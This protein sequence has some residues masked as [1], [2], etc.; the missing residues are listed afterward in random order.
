MYV[1]IKDIGS[2]M[3]TRVLVGGPQIWLL[4]SILTVVEHTA[5]VHDD[6][7]FISYNEPPPPA[8]KQMTIAL[9]FRL[10]H[11]ILS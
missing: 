1:V 3:A 4:L 11:S 10:V 5:R 6:V 8:T 7:V 2:T 9:S